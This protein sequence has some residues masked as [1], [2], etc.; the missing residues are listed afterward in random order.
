MSLKLALEHLQ[1]GPCYHMIEVFQRPNDVA[2]WQDALRSDGATADWDQV[3][4][5][6]QSTA[7]CPACYFWIPLLQ[8]Y[9]NAR[10]V[11]TVRDP[12]SW[13]DSFR[14]TVFEACM[15]PERAPDEEHRIVQ[16]MVRELIMDT[17]FAG[18]FLDRSYAVACMEAHNQAVIDAIPA[19]QLLVYQI[20]DG[21]EPLCR[22]LNVDVPDAPF[23]QVNTRQEFQQ[24][25]AVGP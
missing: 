17:M 14:N 2:F 16:Q 10:Y 5:E 6:F 13:Y 8:H 7:D 22:F 15:H 9:P 18:R 1:F 11:L 21:W 12:E 3:F 19:E 25:F 23:P 4:R 20:A 24:R